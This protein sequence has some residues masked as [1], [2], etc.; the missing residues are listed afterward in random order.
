MERYDPC[1]HCGA[2]CDDGDCEYL[3]GDRLLG[4]LW[5]HLEESNHTGETIIP[6]SVGDRIEEYFKGRMFIPTIYD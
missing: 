2:V 5:C 4:T 6:A 3:E 1:E